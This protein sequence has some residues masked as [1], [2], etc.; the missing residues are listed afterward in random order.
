ME[1]Y[2]AFF[3]LIDAYMI[4]CYH[5]HWS[6]AFSA[7]TLLIRWQEGH[8][9]CE[10]PSGGMLAWLTYE[11]GSRCRFAYDPADATAAHYLLL[12]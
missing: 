7:L 8:P 2:G 4:V 5:Y 1:H 11:S 12:Q 6:N 10:N 3:L 9:A